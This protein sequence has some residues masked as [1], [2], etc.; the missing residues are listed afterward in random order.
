MTNR[1]NG[2]FDPTSIESFRV[3]YSKVLETPEDIEMDPYTG[4][5]T[6]TVSNT[7]PWAEHT[8]LWKANPGNEVLFKP[9]QVLETKGQRQVSEEEMSEEE[10]EFLLEKLKLAEEELVESEEEEFDSDLEELLEELLEEEEEE[11]DSDEEL[12]ISA[13][14]LEDLLDELSQELED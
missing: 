1:I 7:S 11:F 14:E 8:G 3:A 5:P 4:L 13:E 2:D 10:I 12:D 9:N 6:N